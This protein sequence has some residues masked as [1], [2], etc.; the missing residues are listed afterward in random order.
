M[1]QNF[2]W[3][4]TIIPI[5]FIKSE[6]EIAL[7]PSCDSLLEY[8][9][10]VVRQ[11]RDKTGEIEKYSIRILK[12]INKSCPTSYH[13]ELPD[14]IT[15]YR[16]YSTDSIEEAITQSNTEITV[17]ADESTIRRWR[18]W[19]EANAINI[20]MALVSVSAVTFG[21]EKSSSLE[22][23]STKSPIESIKRVVARHVRWLNEAV[24][25]LVNSS[26][27]FFNRSAFLT[28]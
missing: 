18:K 2:K 13:R 23:Q 28:G 21:N 22:I 9:C 8:H 20:I 6:E 12:C 11:L 27:W 15:P 24:R 5:F 1:Y 3:N 10:R 4:I 7:C 14:I 26:K 19:F 16:R 17:A 25:I